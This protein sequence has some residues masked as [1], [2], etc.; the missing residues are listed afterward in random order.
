MVN[1]NENISHKLMGLKFSEQ[2]ETLRQSLVSSLPT[3]DVAEV[4]FSAFLI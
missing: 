2:V 4:N 3:E 1:Q